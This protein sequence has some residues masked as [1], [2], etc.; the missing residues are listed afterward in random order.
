M[1]NKTV[2]LSI[3]IVN[4]KN[5]QRTVR[6]IREELIKVTTPHVVVVVNNSATD[7]SN[8]ALVDG[9]EGALVTDVS[10][11][12]EGVSNI[13]VLPHTDN[14]GFARGNNLGAE[15]SIKHFSI[16]HFLFSNNDI[17]LSDSDV[18]ERLIEK[19]G[20]LPD[21]AL[22]GPRILGLDGKN[23]SPEPY[24]PFWNRY[25]WLYWSSLLF[26]T[27]KKVSLFRLDY[28]QK[29]E[30]GEHYKLMGAFFIVRAADFFK[31]GMMD[32]NTFLFA[33]E[34]ILA[35]RMAGIGKKN[36]YYPSVKIFHEH[37][38]TISNHLDC[39]KKAWIQFQSES[40]YYR[41]YKKVSS[42]SIAI[43]KFSLLFYLRIKNR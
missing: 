27:Q 18:V 2:M 30:E 16:S 38:E 23:Q 12:P 4:Y 31:C 35:E 15:F 24:V 1:T 36:Y 40:Y 8:Q 34:V 19:L 9:L 6:Y 26:S 25:V 13:F 29:A 37:S 33:E 20:D 32:P 28:P 41:T 5:E 14:L 43:G 42:L 11:L 17:V 3:V 10:F 21:V 7:A 39:R 22:I